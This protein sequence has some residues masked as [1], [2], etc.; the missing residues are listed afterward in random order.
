[1]RVLLV[2]AGGVGEAIVSIATKNDPNAEWLTCMVVCDYDFTR[3]KKVVSTINDKRLTAEIIDASDKAQI[4]ALAKQ[5]KV[6][7]IMN[8]CDPIFNMPIFEAALEIGVRYMDMAMSISH[9]DK[10][11]P[12]GK[13]GVKLGDVQYD[14]HD[15]WVE[16][17]NLALCGSGVEPGMV[18]VFARYAC[19]Y[20]FDEIHELNVRDADNMEVE[21]ID[22]AFGFSI[23]TTIE[24]C[25][26]PPIIWEKDRGWYVTESFSEPE[27]FRF[28]EPVGDQEVI[29]IEHEEVL[30]FPRYFK[31][32]GLKRVTFK[33]G[34]TRDMRRVLKILE[35]LGLTSTE[36]VSI[37]GVEVSPRDV[38]AVCSPNPAAIGDK[39]VGQLSAG[40]WVKGLKDGKERSVYIYQLVDNEDCMKKYGSQAVVA[41][42]AV[43]P[44]IMM[45][46][47][48]KGIWDGKG[49]LGPENFP[50]EPFMQRLPS[51]GFPSK[52]MELE[53][54][55]KKA[56]DE[57]AFKQGF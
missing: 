34:V 17:N 8:A 9:R 51:Y 20:L 1:M 41:Q 5:Y 42:T 54:E 32:K 12:Y 47:M 55:Y 4:I 7:F 18:N 19:D 6:D 3:A 33:F 35:A 27:I 37:K 39:M 22:I 48:S 44:V 53:S 50:P 16:K 45:E 24:E 40:L 28:P 56:E 30:M 52:M 14:Q 15:L 49:V 31:D 21:G 36:K 43:G 10:Q 11:D 46:L 57:K 23:W 13:V 38:V 2:G 29:N 25:L 26:N